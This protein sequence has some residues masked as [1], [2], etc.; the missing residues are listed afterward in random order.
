MTDGTFLL[1]GP[2][3]ASA[4]SVTA[5]VSPWLCLGFFLGVGTTLVA[6]AIAAAQFE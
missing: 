2:V 3:L 6:G 5:A 1:F 4:A